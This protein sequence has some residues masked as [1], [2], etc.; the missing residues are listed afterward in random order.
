MGIS[1][2]LWRAR[3]GLFSGGRGLRPHSKAPSTKHQP[4]HF[5]D[6]VGTTGT[7]VQGGLLLL[8]LIFKFLSQD[9]SLLL[10]RT[11]NVGLLM[12]AIVG[13]VHS[14]AH[15]LLLAGD[16]ESNPGPRMNEVLSLRGHLKDVCSKLFKARTEWLNIGLTL[17]VDYNTLTAINQKQSSNHG[18]CLREMLAHCIQATDSLTWE[19][20]CRSLR[21]IT[22]G[23]SDVA[24]EIEGCVSDDRLTLDD[25]SQAHTELYNS[26][27]R[28]IEIGQ[29]LNVDDVT[30]DSIRKQFANDDSTCLREML[31]HRLKSGPPLTWEDTLSS[32]QQP[33]ALVVH[34]RPQ[35][36]PSVD[37]VMTSLRNLG[38][39]QQAFLDA[40]G[41]GNVGVVLELL[42]CGADPNQ[43]DKDDDWTALYWASRNGRDEIVRVLLAAKATVNT[44]T[45]SGETPLWTA[46]FNGHQ[47]CMELLIDAGANVDVPRE[48]GVTAL[49][50]AAQEGHERAVELLIAA[51][52]QV[53]IQN[54]DGVTALHMASQEG[55]CGVVR[56][57]LEAKANVHIM[58]NN[59][60]TALHV[61]NHHGHDEIMRVLLAAKATVNTQEKSGETPLWTASFSGH[62]K[63]MELLIDAGANVDVPKEGGVTALWVAAQ[64]GH[65]R[66]VELLIAAKARVDIQYKDGVTALHKA[67]QKG[68]CGVVRMLLEAK[69]NVHIKTND[70]WTAYD[71]ASENGHTQVCELLH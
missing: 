14:L 13:L 53:N 10:K 16:V 24:N 6:T 4:L 27:N 68:H 67:S 55:H 38:P 43:A 71:L 57:L 17:N 64:E 25:L 58:A 39:Q 45:K 50:V 32:M 37:Q 2:E 8:L 30:L 66:A 28:W 65:E 62:Q 23:R 69:A 52:A 9:K 31:A 49:W 12:I 20:L 3:I 59:N 41:T 34:D 1:V 61:A 15:L 26:R 29:A 5:S 42:E 11:R 54:E 7:L 51:K 22:V 18:D 63:C 47:K 60:Q 46:S 19:D 44:Q 36:R 48:D 40:C 56:M 70:G 21:H 35:Q 33:S